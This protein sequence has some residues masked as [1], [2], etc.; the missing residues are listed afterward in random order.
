MRFC[1]GI[2]T[3]HIRKLKQTALRDPL[4]QG[5]CFS[6]KRKVL[7][8]SQHR[9]REPAILHPKRHPP[10]A[11]SKTPRKRSSP[12]TGTENSEL[13][14]SN[15]PKFSSAGSATKRKSSKRKCTRLRTAADAASP[16]APREPP[17]SCAPS[18]EPT[19]STAWSTASST[20]APC[21]AESVPPPDAAA[22]FTRSAW[23][24]QEKSRPNSTPSASP[25]SFTT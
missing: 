1:T 3:E 9:R 19:H 24:T 5:I 20:S 13:R 11:S 7:C 23:K 10:G 15:I 17:A 16:S 14:S 25:C 12:F 8:R 21:S 2:I 6:G 22:S 18:P 4:L